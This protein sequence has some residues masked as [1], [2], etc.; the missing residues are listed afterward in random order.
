MA[1]LT[2]GLSLL[3]FEK[4]IELNHEEKRNSKCP[5]AYGLFSILNLCF[6]PKQFC[7]EGRSNKHLIKFLPHTLFLILLKGEK[8]VKFISY[9]IPA[10]QQIEHTIKIDLLAI[11]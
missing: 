2:Y 4:D 9:Q 6:S 10:Y 8:F 7:L 3:E 5:S 11:A 1:A